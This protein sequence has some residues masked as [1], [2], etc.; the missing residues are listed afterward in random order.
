VLPLTYLPK[1]FYSLTGLVM[2]SM[3]PDFEYFLRM[4]TNGQYGHS[5]PG[6]FWFDLPLAIIL[7]FTYHQLVRNTLIDNTLN[8]LYGRLSKF[9]E[10]HWPKYFKAHWLVVCISIIIG[11]GT[12]LLWDSFTHYN[13]YFVKVIPTL[14]MNIILLGHP[15]FIFKLLQYLCSLIGAVVIVIV[16]FSLPKQPGAQQKISGRYWVLVFLISIL[17]LAVRLLVGFKE[18]LYANLLISSISSGLF[19]LIL[20]PLIIKRLN[21]Q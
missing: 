21:I 7:S 9:K 8:I 17:I 10:F 14:A 5:L 11:T 12:H 3:V 2:G 18:G 15:I 20:A 13:G 19:A 16:V 6:M 1:K 4:S